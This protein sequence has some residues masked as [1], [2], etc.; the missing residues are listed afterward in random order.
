MTWTNFTGL[1]GIILVG[2]ILLTFVRRSPKGRYY[3]NQL[4]LGAIRRRCH[5]R[6]LFFALT[7]D[8]EFYDREATFKKL[9][10]VYKFGGIRITLEFQA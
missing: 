2:I 5:K 8:N 4:N 1:V 10:G 7:I 6:P 3:G 9:N